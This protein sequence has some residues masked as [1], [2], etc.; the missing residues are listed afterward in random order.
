MES[1]PFLL[2]S[3]LWRSR[4]QAKLFVTENSKTIIIV[5]SCDLPSVAKALVS[6]PAAKDVHPAFIVWM[7]RHDLKIQ[8]L[9]YTVHKFDHF[10]IGKKRTCG[11]LRGSKEC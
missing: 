6:G 2:G 1:S 8:I 10:G 3:T 5:V 7:V 4:W 9:K 11:F